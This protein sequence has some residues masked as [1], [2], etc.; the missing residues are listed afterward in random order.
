[1]ALKLRP[2]VPIVG[3]N[4]T[5]FARPDHISGKILKGEAEFNALWD[6]KIR[7]KGKC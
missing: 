3:Q 1:M 2:G 5:L 6:L 7:L 4:G